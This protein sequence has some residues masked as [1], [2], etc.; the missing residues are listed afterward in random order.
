MVMTRIKFSFLAI[1]MATVMMLGVSSAVYAAV[2]CDSAEIVKVGT[3][4]GAGGGTASDNVIGIKCLSDTSW[5]NYVGLVPNAAIGDQ[6][7]ATALTAFSL[8]KTVW[9]RASAKTAGSML[10]VIYLNK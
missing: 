3:N 8:D 6:A 7:L 9:I 5:G 10:T 2:D 4:A 1:C